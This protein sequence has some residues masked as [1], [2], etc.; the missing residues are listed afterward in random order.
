[1]RIMVSAVRHSIEGGLLIERWQPDGGF[2]M[3]YGRGLI[4][5]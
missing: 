5:P 4:S 3:L 1:M 2:T